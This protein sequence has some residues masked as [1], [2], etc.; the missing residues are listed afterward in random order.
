MWQQG[1][2]AVLHPVE[3]S[4]AEVPRVR[5]GGRA[6]NA[7]AA[8][9]HDFLRLPRPHRVRRWGRVC[10][11]DAPR[12]LHSAR[13]VLAGQGDAVDQPGRRCE[14]LQSSR[15][16]GQAE[17]DH[18]HVVQHLV[19]K[20]SS[21]DAGACG[22]AALRGV[23]NGVRAG[24]LHGARVTPHGN[25]PVEPVQRNSAACW[26]LGVSGVAVEVGV[27]AHV[28]HAGRR[29]WR[30][31]RENVARS[32]RVRLRLA[33]VRDGQGIIHDHILSLVRH[34]LDGE[35]RDALAFVSQ[36]RLVVLKLFIQGDIHARLARRAR[37]HRVPPG[38]GR[39][40]VVR[41]DLHGAHHAPTVTPEGRVCFRRAIRRV[42]RTVRRVEAHELHA[43]H[44]EGI[45][46]QQHNPLAFV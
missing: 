31:R 2:L 34:G 8:V 24:S 29:G 9:L 30:G 19:D 37:A 23:L 17:A 25:A 18:F 46:A 40:R 3:G 39:R 38:D 35:L 32:A 43:R 28:V 21:A 10:P 36:K 41:P 5:R 11:V 27:G 33:A 12:A 1:R 15:R 4:T 13:P 42:R 6:E 45:P 14:V 20:I 22:R 7:N 44:P 26:R 16:H